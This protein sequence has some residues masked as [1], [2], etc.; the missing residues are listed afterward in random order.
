MRNLQLVKL[1]GMNCYKIIEVQTDGKV[2]IIGALDFY[3]KMKKS[4]DFED[5]GTIRI[6]V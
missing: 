6:Y 2:V 1:N 3:E 5:E 4:P